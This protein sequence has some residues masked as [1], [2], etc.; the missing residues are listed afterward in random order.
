MCLLMYITLNNG[1]NY[2]LGWILPFFKFWENDNTRSTE[3]LD[4]DYSP[5]IILCTEWRHNWH[6]DTHKII[7]MQ[8]NNSNLTHATCRERID[9]R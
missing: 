7:D 8:Y 3:W 1:E 4:D 2:A 9:L 6:Y 5:E